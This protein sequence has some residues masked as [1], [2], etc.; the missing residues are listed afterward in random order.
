[1]ACQLCHRAM[2]G[3]RAQELAREKLDSALG[4]QRKGAGWKDPNCAV[5]TIHVAAWRGS[6]GCVQTLGLWQG[7][8]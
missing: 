3:N 8:K 2:A 6:Q 7:T 5:L 1:M 4:V